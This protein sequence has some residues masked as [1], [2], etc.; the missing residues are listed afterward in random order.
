MATMVADPVFVGTTVLLCTSRPTA[1]EHV[2]ARAGLRRLVEQAHDANIVATMQAHG[3]S[4]LLTFNTSDFRR[5][6]ALVDL[7]PL[8]AI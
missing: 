8:P 6:G 5:F 1:P 4:R 2:I 3:V 7:N